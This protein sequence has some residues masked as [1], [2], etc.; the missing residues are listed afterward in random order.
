MHLR[1][2]KFDICELMDEVDESN[3][4]SRADCVSEIKDDVFF[5]S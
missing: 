3:P 5:E 4:S 2:E 1:I